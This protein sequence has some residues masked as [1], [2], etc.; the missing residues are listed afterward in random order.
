M[1]LHLREIAKTHLETRFVSINA[2]KSPFF[3]TKLQIQVLPT[4]I[5]FTNGKAEDRVT[6][7]EELG[8]EDEFDTLVL[9]RRLVRGKIID[10]KNKAE[11]GRIKIKKG[12]AAKQDSSDDDDY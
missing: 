7:F 12:K 5:M 1:D 6:G 2:E 8:G 4:V 11:A 9:T 10:P 3:I